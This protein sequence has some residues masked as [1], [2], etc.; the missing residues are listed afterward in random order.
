MGLCSDVLYFS[1]C[2]DLY[3]YLAD[4]RSSELEDPSLSIQAVHADALR[5]SIVKKFQDEIGPSADLAALEKF[6]ASNRACQTW[7]I[8]PG[9]PW[10]ME[11]MLGE[12]KAELYNFFYPGGEPLLDEP[13]IWR[14]ADIGPGT[15]AGVEGFSFLHK[16]GLEPV[17]ASSVWLFDAWKASFANDGVRVL[18]DMCRRRI[19]GTDW[20]LINE[21]TL[22]FA[23]K[24][25][26]V[27]RAIQPQPSINM[28]YQKGCGALI[29]SRLTT[30]YGIDLRVQPRLNQ[31]LARRGSVDGRF[32]TID[33]ESA[34][35]RN[36][37]KML[38]EV[39]PREVFRWLSL[40]RVPKVKYPD[41]EVEEL[42]MFSTMGNGY[43]FSLQTVLFC[44]VVAAVYR[45]LEIPAYWPRVRIRQPWRFADSWLDPTRFV[46]ERLGNIGVFGDDIVVDARAYDLTC[47]TLEFLGHRVNRD[48]SFNEGFF[49]ESC[50]TDWFKGANVRGVYCKTLK[51]D[52]DVLS[53]TN[54]LIAWSVKTGIDLP[55][56]LET[57]RGML[58]RQPPLVPHFEDDQAGLKVPLDAIGRTRRNSNGS[59]AYGRYRVKPKRLWFLDGFA[60][61]SVYLHCRNE[62]AAYLAA[63]RGELR[64]GMLSVR[65]WKVAYH[66]RW[67]V[68]PCWEDRRLAPALF[69]PVGYLRW[70]CA[71]TSFLTGNVVEPG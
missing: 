35:D 37:L 30:F 7:E 46:I 19:A 51:T 29:N 61:D 44:A 57:L 36:S 42:H 39:L 33:L 15:A 40:G 53:L 55:V 59:F 65:I 9:A 60:E 41:G 32:G 52:Q 67:A 18:A 48:K 38:K 5:K 1:V 47:R 14:E 31:E 23:P 63:L 17:T 6:R 70:L 26:E 27:S 22:T 10:V 11:Y 50:G 58:Q 3:P 49:R 43:T 66:Y 4:I 34:S 12:V 25:S 45:M 21:G 13:R 69:E 54:R 16:R 64:G 56:T 2:L 8:D 24:T 71:V 28:E 20:R 62:P 68:T